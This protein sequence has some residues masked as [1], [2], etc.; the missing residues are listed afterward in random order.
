MASDSMLLRCLTG[1]HAFEGPT[2][3]SALARLSAD[4][5]IPADLPSGWRELLTSMTARAPLD[6]PT[7]AD[8]AGRL[9][10]LSGA[11]TTTR[12]VPPAPVARSATAR[13]HDTRLAAA[14]WLHA[15]R[16]RVSPVAVGVVLLAVLLFA[17]AAMAGHDPG[18]GEPVTN[19]PNSQTD[20][21]PQT[22]PV[23]DQQVAQVEPVAQAVTPKAEEPAAAGSHQPKAKH[24]KNKKDKGKPGKGKGKPG[25]G[26]PGR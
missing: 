19:P 26:K 20:P 11:R 24:H 9:A 5:E 13:T 2:I 15:A 6:R 10:W 16:S 22:E 25:K 3:E 21:G 17:A 23:T 14:R 18:S 12:V 7:A 1:K 8:V 4:P